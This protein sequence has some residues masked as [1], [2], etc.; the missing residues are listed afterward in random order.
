MIDKPEYIELQSR[1]GRGWNTWNTRSLL[2]W[3]QLP[4]AIALNLGIKSYCG[5]DHVRE[6]FVGQHD[7]RLAGHSYDGS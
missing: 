2:C 4:S 5:G 1:L 7:V 3:V 6:F